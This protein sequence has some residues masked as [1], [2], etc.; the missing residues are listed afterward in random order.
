MADEKLNLP[1]GYDPEAD[2]V[3]AITQQIDKDTTLLVNGIKQLRTIGYQAK[4]LDDERK[5]LTRELLPLMRK[6]ITLLDPMTGKPILA[7]GIQAK[8]IKVDAAELRK[9]LLEH[10]IEEYDVDTIMA[11][12]VKPPE[13]DTKED[14]LF[15]TAVRNG[16][17]PLE[18]VAKVAREKPSSAYIGFPTKQPGKPRQ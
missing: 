8:P 14:G 5:K 10:G 6:P 15:E 9:A 17:I 2:P 12:V 16:K 13:V 4:I 3:D 18:V 7:A 1:E 11:D